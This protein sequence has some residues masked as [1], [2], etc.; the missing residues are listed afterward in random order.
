MNIAIIGAGISGLVTA[1]LLHR[2]HHITVFEANDY[3]GGHTRTVEV[4]DG[5]RTQAVDTGFIVFNDK[6]YPNFVRLMGRLGISRRPSRMSF[7]VK[8]EKT[9][10]EYSPSSP[11]AL[12]AR[13]Q[14]LLSLPFYRMLLDIF[15]FRLGSKAL[16]LEN[17]PRVTLGE[18]LSRKRYSRSFVRHF[19]LPM[20]AAIWSADPKGFRLFPARYF[21]QF[22]DNHG[23]LNVVHQPRWYVIQGG[24]SAYVGPLTHPFIERIRVNSPVQSVRRNADY[25]EITAR[26]GKPEQFDAV[27]IAAHSDQALAMLVDPS[28]EERAVLRS[29]PY[30]E[31]EVLLHTDISVLP[32]RRAAW[33]SWNYRIPRNGRD[34]VHV[35]Y[36]MNMLQSLD[37][38]KT[39]CVS[40]NQNRDIRSEHTLREFVYHH[41]VYHPDGVAAQGRRE[42]INGKNR[43]WFC[44]AYWGA[45]FHEDGVNSALAVCK[46]FGKTLDDA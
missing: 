16:L 11:N 38:A 33:A 35:T 22:F 28:D 31:N 45:G 21:V 44:G 34:R 5:E 13:R 46:D 30:Q 29:I 20:G 37:A 15:R 9:G 39:F 43:T 7:S 19:I 3:I 32:D 41:P 18:Y 40:L 10:L 23:F 36:N 27:V 4:S 26:T 6:T 25:V 2:D 24:S 42:R 1:Y 12:F 17:D 14:N 8:C